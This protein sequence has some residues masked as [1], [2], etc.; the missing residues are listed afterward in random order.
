MQLEGQTFAA[1][2]AELRRPVQFKKLDES[3]QLEPLRAG[4]PLT[5]DLR[6]RLLQ[7]SFRHD[8]CNGVIEVELG[9][10]R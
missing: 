1:T 7:R 9:V 5:G 4:N 10:Q 6:G 8:C 3:D 2:T